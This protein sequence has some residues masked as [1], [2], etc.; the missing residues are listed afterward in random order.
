MSTI[1]KSVH[2]RIKR[3]RAG[4]VTGHTWR[5]RYISPANAKEYTRHFTTK[6]EAEDW[7]DSETARLVTGEWIDPASGAMT[8][9]SFYLGYADLQL[10][11]PGTRSSADLAALSTPFADKPIRAITTLHIQA[12]VKRMDANLA[13]T[14]IKTRFTHVRATFRAAVLAKE[15][16]A[17]PTAGVKLP[18][19]RKQSAAMQIPE[20]EQVALMLRASSDKWRP[21][22]AVC[23][24][25]GLRLGEAAALQVEDVDFLKRVIRVQRQV[26]RRKGGGADI[27]LPK[28]GSER[29]VELPEELANLLASHIEKHVLATSD[30]TRW[31]FGFDSPPNQNVVGD[32]WREVRIDGFRLHDLRHF[33]ASGLIRAGLDVVTVQRALGHSSPTVTLSTYSHLW[34]DASERTRKAAD[35]LLQQVLDYG[36]TTE[37]ETGGSER[38]TA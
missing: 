7:L 17:D 19:R 14:T 9:R 24:F 1:Q 34:P 21:L 11:K 27:S 8:F 38:E 33:Y 23:A 29:A 5:A 32:R 35:G 16:S 25:A 3:N 18:A 36:W 12:W 2:K 37:P 26:Q 20:P 31:M 28:F 4:E 10:W 22:F 30:G 6:R 13:P 15:I